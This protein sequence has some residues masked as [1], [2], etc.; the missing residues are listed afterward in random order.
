MSNYAELQAQNFEHLLQVHL[1]SF[2]L[3]KVA[4]PSRVSAGFG[5]P[6]TS[7][8]LVRAHKFHVLI[9]SLWE[10]RAR[11]GLIVPAAGGGTGQQITQRSYE[12]TKKIQVV[13]SKTL[14]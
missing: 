9:P 12:Y 1:T 7:S 5:R 3:V 10:V 2:E 6:L 11:K 8:E 13:K 4:Q 14:E